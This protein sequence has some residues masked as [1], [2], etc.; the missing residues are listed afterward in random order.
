M[1]DADC[2]DSHTLRHGNSLPISTWRTISLAAVCWRSPRRHSLPQ[3]TTPTPLQLRREQDQRQQRVRAECHC[4]DYPSGISNMLESRSYSNLPRHERFLR[5][6]NRPARRLPVIPPILEIN[7]ERRSNRRAICSRVHQRSTADTNTT[8][9]AKLSSPALRYRE[10]AQSNRVRIH[11]D[12]LQRPESQRRFNLQRVTIRR[13][14]LRRRQRPRRPALH[15]V[16]E[17]DRLPRLG[18]HRHQNML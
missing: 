10:P 18:D 9:K 12:I 15:G 7:L 11:R 1:G 14:P 17:T 16:L 6:R 13:P 2:G 5:R 3:S 4:I 8:T